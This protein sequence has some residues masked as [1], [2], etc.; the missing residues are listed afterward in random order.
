MNAIELVKKYLPVLD[1]QYRQL[2][3]TAVLDMPREWVRD[4]KD[5]K[6]V[7]IA[8][9]KTDKLGGYSRANGF[10]KGSMDLSWEEHEFT[11]DRGRSIQVDHEDNEETFGMAFGRLA[12]RFQK[13]AVIPELDA[14]RISVYASGAGHKEAM[15]LGA[16]S[17]LRKIDHLDA[18]MDDEEV[19]EEGRIVFLIPSVYEE[20]INDASVEKKL[21]VND[22]MAKALNK[23]I[24]SYN[25]HPLI[26][27]TSKRMYTAIK[28]LDGSTP[29]EEEGGYEKAVGASDLGLLMVTQDAV[30]QISKRAVARIW[31][32]S[33]EYAAGCDGV[34]PDA[35][36]WKF[37]FR[38]YHDAWV[39]DEK[40][41]GIA[42][43]I[44]DATN[45]E[46]GKYENDAFA[47]GNSYTINKSGAVKG[48]IPQGAAVPA[49]N[50]DAG[51]RFV[52][53]LSNPSITAQSQLP[54]GNIVKTTNSNT[55]YVNEKDRTVFEA[56]G[57]LIVVTNIQDANTVYTVEIEW[58]KGYK[59]TYKFTFEGCTFTPAH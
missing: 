59:S 14:Y 24:Y 4:T 25:G 55:G 11:Q 26:K 48:T 23:K 56:D 28:L 2:S 12:G 27:I 13:D 18:L 38:V 5:A 50:L 32:P 8:K 37:D 3:K 10:V 51:N 1:E 49:I 36:A 47:P 58:T 45:I 57:S 16:G 31:A 22:E 42:A 52:I 33:R 29:G 20:A 46:V 53:K 15:V 9:Y 6:K 40:V 35:D 19:P 21:E 44:L 7:K 30:V 17:V 43:L 41:N 39:L 54:T 34:N